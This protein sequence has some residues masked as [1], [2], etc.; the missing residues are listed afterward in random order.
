[1]ETCEKGVSMEPRD[2]DYHDTRGLA[3]AL[4]SDITGAI[5]DFS[6][7]VAWTADA[8]MKEQRSHWIKV[9]K[10]GGNPFTPAVLQTL[11]QN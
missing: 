7:F 5:D 3:R 10:D 11:L 9:L 6:F 4:T 8:Q 2:G 1:M